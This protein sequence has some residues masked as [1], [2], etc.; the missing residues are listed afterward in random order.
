MDQPKCFI[1][2]EQHT[3]AHNERE[4]ALFD[5]IMTLIYPGFVG[6][7][8]IETDENCSPD[9]PAC[10]G[11]DKQVMIVKHERFTVQN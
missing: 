4:S 7:V 10:H 8:M 2:A 9:C 1:P 6:T 11:E 3:D 5:H